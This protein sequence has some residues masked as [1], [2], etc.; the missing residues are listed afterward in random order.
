MI[1]IGLVGV[2]KVGRD[3]LHAASIRTLKPVRPEQALLAKVRQNT[4]ASTTTSYDDLLRDPATRRHRA[5]IGRADSLRWQ[6]KHWRRANV[7][8]SQ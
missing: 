7:L 8:V 5:G 6:R 4:P 2:G 1:G 3:W